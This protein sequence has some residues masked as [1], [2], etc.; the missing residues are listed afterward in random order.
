MFPINYFSI[1]FLI[2]F[3][4]ENRQREAC[5]ETQAEVT[6]LRKQIKDLNLKVSDVEAL[7]K[8]IKEKDVSSLILIIT[9]TLTLW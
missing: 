1:N 2:Q 9:Y 5:A 4:A 8:T 6:M 7:N 3:Q